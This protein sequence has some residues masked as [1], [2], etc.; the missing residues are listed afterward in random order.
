MS[1][2]IAVA[3]LVAIASAALACGV[4]EGPREKFKHSAFNFNEGLRW[5]R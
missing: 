1:T 3:V 5:G 4:A 2:R